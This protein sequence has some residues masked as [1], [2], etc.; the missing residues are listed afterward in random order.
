MPGRGTWLDAWPQAKRPAL[1]RGDIVYGSA[2]VRREAET[3]DQLSRTT[4]RLPKNVQ[5]LI[6]EP[7]FE[8]TAVS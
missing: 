7:W 6:K 5:H 1:R 2:S 3:R 4:L 8:L